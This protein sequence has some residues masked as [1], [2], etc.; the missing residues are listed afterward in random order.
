M[1]RPFT[2]EDLWAIRRVG[3]PSP[4]RDGSFVVVPVTD[5][6][7]DHPS[8]NTTLYLL[9][10]GAEPRQ[11]TSSEHSSTEPAISPDDASIAFVRKKEGAS[12]TSCHSG[13]ENPR[14]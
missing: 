13:A 4:A 5:Y 2:P 8:G 1:P 6:D 3:Q 10:D 7:D 9:A 11:I 14:G 12:S